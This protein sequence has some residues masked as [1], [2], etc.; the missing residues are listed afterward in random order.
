MERWAKSVNTQKAVQQQVIHQIVE[1]EQILLAEQQMSSANEFE[2]DVH[3]PF[4]IQVNVCTCTCTCSVFICTIW[5]TCTCTSSVFISV[6]MYH[7]YYMY[8]YNCMY[9]LLEP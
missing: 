9:I 1:Q 2:K 7:L 4:G 8:M 3:V 5:Y 6:Y